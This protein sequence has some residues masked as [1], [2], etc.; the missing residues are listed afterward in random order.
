[1]GR[2]DEVLLLDKTGVGQA[3]TEG[4]D[5]RM[6]RFANP[7]DALWSLLLSLRDSRHAYRAGCGKQAAARWSAAL[8]GSW[9]DP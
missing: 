1:M 2:N 6:G 4:Y 5:E 8:C 9:H 3:A 7:G